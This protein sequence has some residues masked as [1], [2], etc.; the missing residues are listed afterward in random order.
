MSWHRSFAIAE[1]VVRQILR[2]RR[3]LGLIIVA[4]LLVMTLV[5]GSFS[6]QSAILNRTAPALIATFAMFF[7]FLLTGVSFLRERSQGT[8]ERLLATPVGRLDILAGYLLGFLLF[9]LIQSTAVLL[10]TVFILDGQY[11]GDLLQVFVV[12][13]VLTVASISMGIFIATFARNEFQVVQF[14]PVVLAPQI[15]VSGIM[16]PVE[17]MPTALRWLA[18]VAPLRYAVDAMRALMLQGKGLSDVTSEL[19]AVAI[20]AVAMLVSAVFAVRRT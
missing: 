9:A 20:F 1:R 7:T 12:L 8:L 13:L 4:P 10:H 3:S 19:G 18:N 2:D 6:G 16:V 11:S 15:F 14:I 5:G 17:T